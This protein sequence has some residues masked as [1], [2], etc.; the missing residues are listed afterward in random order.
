M[1]SQS[2]G[3][4][5]RI[6]ASMQYPIALS[7]SILSANLWSLP[8]LSLTHYILEIGISNTDIIITSI[9][10]IN[11]TNIVSI[12]NIVIISQ[13]S[14]IKINVILVHAISVMAIWIQK[15]VICIQYQMPV[16]SQMW[17]VGHLTE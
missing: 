9:K 2:D 1:A 13:I 7:L 11:S 12:I 6:L 4:R 8:L 3:N 17:I 14:I 15:I 5:H 16:M 10:I